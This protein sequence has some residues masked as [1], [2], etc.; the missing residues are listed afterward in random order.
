MWACCMHGIYKVCTVA[1]LFFSPLPRL[2]RKGKGK[3]SKA[4]QRKE[5]K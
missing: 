3:H 4:R 5:R 2:G 1:N